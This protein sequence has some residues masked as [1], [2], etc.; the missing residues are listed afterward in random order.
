VIYLR[1]DFEGILRFAFSWIEERKAWKYFLLHLGVNAIFSAIVFWLMF[2]FFAN[3]WI[4]LIT[5]QMTEEQLKAFMLNLFLDKEFLTKVITFIGIILILIII[6]SLALLYVV[7]LMMLYAL[8]SKKLVPARFSA[9][10]YLRFIALLIIKPL[11]ILFY[12]FDKTVLA[13]LWLSLVGGIT[14]V[15][16]TVMFR[17]PLFMFL[18]FAFLIIYIICVIYNVLRL[19][20]SE[21]IFVHRDIGIIDA[22]RDSFKLTENNVLNVFIAAIIIAVAVFFISM[23]ES[24]IPNMLFPEPVAEAALLWLMS[25]AI[26]ALPVQAFIAMLTSF[27]YVGLYAELLKI[28]G[29]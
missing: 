29:E 16:F 23:L 15:M 27:Y 14:S 4:P 7:V 11:V 10:K 12:S 26:V 25:Y 24:L 1:F 3:T 20:V 13:I 8:R 2:A 6:G 18:F 22:F 5:G 19:Y 9:S 21:Q 17:F 28:K